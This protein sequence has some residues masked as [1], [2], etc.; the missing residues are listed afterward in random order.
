MKSQDIAIIGILLAVG[1]IARFA[2]L[3]APL[4]P[5]LMPELCHCLLLSGSHA[6]RPQILPGIGNRIYRR[7]HQCSN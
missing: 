5:F 3:Y 2:A 4:P 6:G 7:D 1:A